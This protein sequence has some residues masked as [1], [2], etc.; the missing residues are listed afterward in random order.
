[1]NWLKKKAKKFKKKAKKAAKKL[2][3]SIKKGIKKVKKAIKRIVKKVKRVIKKIKRVAK[4]VYKKIK[5]AVKKVATKV[6]RAV[7]KFKRAAT[8]SIK[9]IHRTAKKV[10]KKAKTVVQK[11]I[12]KVKRSVKKKITTIKKAGLNFLA[13]AKTKIKVASIVSKI[14]RA[15][16]K[17]VLKAKLNKAS[18]KY[19]EKKIANQLRAQKNWKSVCSGTSALGAGFVDGLANNGTFGMVGTLNKNDQAYGDNNLYHI[20]KILSDIGSIAVGGVG[21]AGGGALA[22]VGVGLDVTG[23]GAVIGVPANIAGVAIA[24]GSA[25]VATSGTQNI[26]KDA[27]DLISNIKGSGGK[28]TSSSAEKILGQNA[29]QISSKTMWQKGKTERVDIENQSPGKNPGNIHYHESNNKKWYYNPA[30]GKFYSDHGFTQ[31]GAPK[32]QKL[33]KDPQIKTAIEKGLKM[34]GN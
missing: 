6:K 30:D 28:E 8:K 21:M 27:S 4:K 14:A 12:Q 32:I 11:K 22:G 13:K 31:V 34:L 15:K 1:M 18:K 5:R 26:V 9:Q 25:A 16:A 23:A 2:K 3:K 7:K 29:P 33:L 24:S 20:G 17:V 10:Y 19:A